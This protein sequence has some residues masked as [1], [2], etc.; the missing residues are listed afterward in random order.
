MKN[1][2]EKKNF[3]SLIRRFNKYVIKKENECWLWIGAKVSK[4][5]G[6]LSYNKKNHGAH[7]ISWLIHQGEIPKKL[8]VLHKCDNPPCT[9]PDHLFLGNQDINMI[10]MHNKG[11]ARYFGLRMQPKKFDSSTIELPIEI[12]INMR[13]EKEKRE[14]Y[15]KKMLLKVTRR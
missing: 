6:Y 10:D 14:K 8:S 12:L 13:N 15:I 3:E 9:N 1:T 7:R 4:G 11:R 5:Y 2:Y